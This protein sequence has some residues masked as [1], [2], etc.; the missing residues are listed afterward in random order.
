MGL[1]AEKLRT[2]LISVHAASVRY[3]PTRTL[4]LRNAFAR[5]FRVKFAKLK[6][7]IFRAVVTEDVFGLAPPSA[8]IRRIMVQE[9]ALATPGHEAFAFPRSADKVKAFMAWLQEQ[10]AAG[11]LEVSERPQ[12][13]QAVEQAWTNKYVQD[14]YE[15]GVQRAR[16]ELAHAGYGVPSM[17]ATGGVLASMS[18]PFHMDRVGLLYTRTFSE[19][20]GVTNAMD[21]VISRVLSQSMADGDGARVIARKLLSTISGV[22]DLSFQDK[23]GRFIPAEQR[24]EMIARTELIR[25]FS[26]AQL[27]EFRTW[28]IVG[29][30]AEVEFRNAGDSRVCSSCSFLQG[31]VYTLD[32]ASGII[33]VHP[34]CR[35][36]WLPVDKTGQ[37]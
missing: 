16:Y 21:Q 34:R 33:P 6:A 37:S 35:C 27:Q 31:K 4:H 19:L 2:P 7:A 30:S 36:C 12:I 24:A 23:I 32:E 10:E 1:P 9:T 3:D 11:L 17:E 25:A 5:A 18:L 20:K 15:R 8:G 13:G 26:E 29:V 28:G 22:G 14:S